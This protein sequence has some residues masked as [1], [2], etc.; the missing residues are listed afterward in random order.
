VAQRQREVK[1]HSRSLRRV[2][3]PSGKPYFVSLRPKA[4]SGVP[5]GPIGSR[6]VA[7]VYLGN[8]RYVVETIASANDQ[9]ESNGMDVLS[10]VEA[11]RAA[12]LIFSR[13]TGLKTRNKNLT[14]PR[15]W[16]ITSCNLGLKDDAPGMRETGLIC[17]FYPGSATTQFRS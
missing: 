7:R 17:I 8:G 13:M 16:K 4:A 11:Q 14:V 5:E 9:A 12:K 1:L 3:P 10:Y 15:F 2:L 6:W